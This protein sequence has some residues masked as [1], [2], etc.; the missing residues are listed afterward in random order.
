M[1]NA[2]SAR[3]WRTSSDGAGRPHA[4]QRIRRFYPA[5]EIVSTSSVST[6]S[7][8]GKE[9]VELAREKMLA[10]RTAAAWC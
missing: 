1:S 8:D 7:K 2:R 4:K 9:G 10:G 6:G 3:S 5:G